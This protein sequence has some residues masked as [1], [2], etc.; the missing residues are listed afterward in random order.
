ML[1]PTELHIR[2]ALFRAIRTFFAKQNFLEVDTPI[3]QPVLLPEANIQ[4]LRAGDYF[5]QTSPESCM[6]RLLARGSG[7]IYQICP[8]FRKE[9][10][11]RLHLEEFTML[12]WYRVEASYL[13]LIKDCRDL[14]TFVVGELKLQFP[15]LAEKNNGLFRYLNEGDCLQ[16]RLFTVTEAF[17]TWCPLTLEEVLAKECFDEML[18]EYIEPHLGQGELSFLYDYPVS[19]ASL[20]RKKHDDPMVAERFEMYIEG[21]EIANG[22]SELTDADEQRQRFEKERELLS[23]MVGE[24]LSMPEKF[25]ADLN[26]LPPSAGIALGVDRLFMLILGKSDITEAVSFAPDDL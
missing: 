21:L 20:A 9:E 7:N 17:A 13:E 14:I 3:R 8:C 25:L 15:Q 4:P 19:M 18:V 16:Q 6:K 10:K 22:F 23:K 5:L 1:A 2:A 26:K 11:G 12:E 24:E